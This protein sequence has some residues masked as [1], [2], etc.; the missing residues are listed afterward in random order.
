MDYLDRYVA[1]KDAHPELDSKTV[2]IYVNAGLITNFI[3]I[4]LPLL[5]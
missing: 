2:I 3:P 4:P 5:I 1:Y